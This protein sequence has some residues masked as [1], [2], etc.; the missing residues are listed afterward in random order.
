MICAAR[1]LRN[2]FGYLTFD[3][4]T[5]ALLQGLS[6]PA[7]AKLQAEIDQAVAGVFNGKLASSQGSQDAL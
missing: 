2:P 3:E 7:K 5:E 1:P 4:A 6:G